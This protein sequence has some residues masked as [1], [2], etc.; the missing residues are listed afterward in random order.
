MKNRHSETGTTFT[1][2]RHRPGHEPTV[3]EH[4]APERAVEQS[5]RAAPATTLPPENYGHGGFKPSPAHEAEGR[6]G[7]K[8]GK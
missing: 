7:V 2:I 5:A 4:A 8:G 1:S 6:I 3:A